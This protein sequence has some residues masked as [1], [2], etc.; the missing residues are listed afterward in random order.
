[1][2]G[3]FT[4]II[5]GLIFL[6]LVVGLYEYFWGHMYGGR[7]YQRKGFTAEA[8][9]LLDEYRKDQD[10]NFKTNKKYDKNL[11]ASGRYEREYKNFKLGFNDVP[12]VAKYCPDCSFSEAR[13]KIAAYAVYES[14][15]IVWSV[16]NNGKLVLLKE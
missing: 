7:Y 11:H 2:P 15:D 16:D 9:I 6:L 14:E 1:M 13:Y 5:G 8:K 10:F 12:I 4:K 3:K